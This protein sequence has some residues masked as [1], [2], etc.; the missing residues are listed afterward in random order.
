MTFLAHYR[1]HTWL[2]ETNAMLDAGLL[3]RRKS[4]Y[5]AFIITAEFAGIG[6]L[7]FFGIILLIATGVF[8][9]LLLYGIANCSPSAC[10]AQEIIAWYPAYI[11]AIV[12]LPLLV[13]SLIIWAGSRLLRDR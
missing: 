8:V 4:A 2:S 7:K 13:I 9:V 11:Y 12:Y 6:M 5:I 1:H 3:S 10:E